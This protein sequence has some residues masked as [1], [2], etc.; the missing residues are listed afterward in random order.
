[1]F[2]NSKLTGPIMMV[3]VMYLAFI[4]RSRTALLCKDARQTISSTTK[5]FD[6]S[7][8]RK[9]KSEREI[10]IN[11]AIKCDDLNQSL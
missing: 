1:M 11:S 3:F 7:P 5:I 9:V 6:I 4:Y 8:V 10:E 2:S